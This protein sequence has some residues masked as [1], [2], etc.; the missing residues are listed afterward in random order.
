MIEKVK[1]RKLNMPML[2]IVITLGILTIVSVLLMKL[3]LG[4][5]SLETKAKDIS[6]ACILVQSTGETIK[7]A[8]SLETA[9]KDLGLE[10]PERMGDTDVYKLY[11]DSKW[12]EVKAPRSY[13]M[14]I[15]ITKT[16]Y[17]QNQMITA[18]ITVI[19]EK[20]YAVIKK[21]MEPLA[22]IM[23]KSYKGS[24]TTARE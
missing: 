14:S 5:N 8:S 23:C 7:A 9:V 15:S 12:Q 6:K 16:E 11:Y 2:E 10:N 4:A 19:K 18:E 24:L 22:S 13:T 17:G 20:A 21:D 1:S 3:F